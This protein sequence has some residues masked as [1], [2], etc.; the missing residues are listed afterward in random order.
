MIRGLWMAGLIVL[1]LGGTAANAVTTLAG[2]V[3]ADNAFVDD[4]VPY[5]GWTNP[6]AVVGPNIMSYA[7]NNPADP[8]AYL[9]AIFVDNSIVNGAGADFALYEAGGSLPGEGEPAKITINGI[10]NTYPTIYTGVGS[11]HR[12]FIDLDDFGVASGD[13]VATIQLWG[14]Y[15][16][17]SGTEYMAIGALNNGVPIPAP[18]AIWLLGLG[19][20][21][22]RAARRNVGQ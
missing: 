15:S 22:L 9:Q 18:A 10:T 8:G 11:A 16:G 17:M 6:S 21:T 12:A 7:Q 3:F 19:L 14:L 5:G 13:R 20:V 4:V 2:Q 1:V